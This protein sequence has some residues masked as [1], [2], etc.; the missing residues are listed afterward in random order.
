MSL[1][2]TSVI[3]Q[4]YDVGPGTYPGLV[5]SIN[6]EISVRFLLVLILGD[7]FPDHRS[8]PEDH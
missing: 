2:L 6:R 7:L 3:N 5:L 4:R 1:L 8:A